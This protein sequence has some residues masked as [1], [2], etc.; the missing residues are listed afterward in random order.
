MRDQL[1]GLD[2]AD[3]LLTDVFDRPSFQARRYLRPWK[4]LSALA[5]DVG[6]TIKSDKDKFQVNIDVQHFDPEDIS[7][8]T[9][10]GFV[11]VEGKHEER[12][13]DHGYISRQFKRR[14]ALPEDCSPETV[15]SRLSS[16]GV[17]TIIAP[18]ASGEKD[19]RAV[20]ITH[21]GPVR[22]KLEDGEENGEME[23]EEKEEKTP[24]KKRRR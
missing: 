15:E 9:A 8:K 21:T 3:D 16:D 6:S 11:V 24:Q 17:L 14:Y 12:K 1:F 18:K 23:P 22:R 5:R 20:P 10:D 13:D 7:V 4:N 2:L 19:E